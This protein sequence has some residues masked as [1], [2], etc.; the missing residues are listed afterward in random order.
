MTDRVLLRMARA[1]FLM[2]QA[3]AWLGDKLVQ[4]VFARHR[5]SAGG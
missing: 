1:L 4:R 5:V 2:S 3:M